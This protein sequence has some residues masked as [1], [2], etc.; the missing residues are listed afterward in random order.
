VSKAQ[1][2]EICHRTGS[3]Q[4]AQLRAAN[5]SGNALFIL[6]MANL[7]VF[8][9]DHVLNQGWTKLLYLNHSAPR[10]WQFV[11]SAFSHGSWQHLSSNLVRRSLPSAVVHACLQ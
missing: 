8:V 11:T 5:Q 9:F 2:I 1:S 3:P 7:A 6:I 10:W 4:K